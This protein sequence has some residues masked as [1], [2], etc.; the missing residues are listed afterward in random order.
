MECQTPS[1]FLMPWKCRQQP[2]PQHQAYPRT[3]NQFLHQVHPVNLSTK[4]T[5]LEERCPLKPVTSI[6]GS[7]RC[8]WPSDAAF[9]STTRSSCSEP[10]RRTSRGTSQGNSIS[11]STSGRDSYTPE[12]IFNITFSRHHERADSF[13]DTSDSIQALQPRRKARRV[14]DAPSFKEKSHNIVSGHVHKLIQEAVEDGVGEL[15]LRYVP[16]L[17]DLPAEIKDLNYAIVYNERGSFSLSNNRLKLFLSSNLFSTIPMDVFALHNLSILSL[18]N[19]NIETIPPEIGLLHNLVELSVGGN[20]L[21][22]LPSQIVLLPKLH[23]LTIHPNPFLNPSEP[24]VPQ[25]SVEVAQLAPNVTVEADIQGGTTLPSSTDS[26]ATVSAHPTP[27]NLLTSGPCN[28]QSDISMAAT[29]SQSHNSVMPAPPSQLSSDSRET[30][31]S[32]S[33]HRLPLHQVKR[34]TKI[35]SLLI[36][37]GST[38][39]NYMA[40]QASQTSAKPRCLSSG[41][42]VV[43]EDA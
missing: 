18:R 5:H 43:K 7:N 19:N 25:S 21:R 2:Q 20:R 4:F 38:I 15:D 33:T 35:P 23:I 17:Y 8:L 41:K 30:V 27:S 14:L 31:P 22:F 29:P 32:H 12:P 9:W 11:K 10:D 3:I 13:K 6:V 28:T 24:S 16:Y 36:L 34:S 37:A 1:D 42:G 39:L 26:L 40:Q